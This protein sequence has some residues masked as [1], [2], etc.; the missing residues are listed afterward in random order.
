MFFHQDK[1]INKFENFLPK[2]FL[3]L[4]EWLVKNKLSILSSKT[5]RSSMLNITYR[6][7][8]ISQYHTAEY[9]GFHLDFNISGDAMAMT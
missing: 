2:K 3:T 4:C 7:H 8:N 9:L 1:D 6:N 5:K